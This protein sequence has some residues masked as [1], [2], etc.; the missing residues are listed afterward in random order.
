MYAEKILNGEKKFEYRKKLCKKDIK[1]IYVYA[2]V[3]VK[4]IIGEVKVVK[5]LEMD[6]EELWEKTQEYSGT[7][8]AFYDKYFEKQ[9]LACAYQLGEVKR[10]DYP[11]T[12]ESQGIQAVP[13]SF[14]YCEELKINFF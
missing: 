13:Q 5:K 11:I 14:M 7:S 9:E 12:L 6:K 10:Y 3:P 8:K 4:K 1:K 2:T